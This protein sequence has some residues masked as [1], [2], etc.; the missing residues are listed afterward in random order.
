M[1]C[2]SCAQC[3][4][5]GKEAQLCS[6]VSESSSSL[7]ISSALRQSFFLA[8]SLLAG[9]GKAGRRRISCLSM[10]VYNSTFDSATS[11]A[12]SLFSFLRTSASASFLSGCV[13][14]RFNDLF[15]EKSQRRYN[16]AVA[17]TNNISDKLGVITK[18]RSAWP[19]CSLTI[20]YFYNGKRRQVARGITRM[21]T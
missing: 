1:T 15:P 3:R 4:L 9:F 21:T 16:K 2:D 17:K 10:F 8:R 13:C 20:T 7:A 19:S 14:G 12:V 18:L 5:A 11:L 6:F